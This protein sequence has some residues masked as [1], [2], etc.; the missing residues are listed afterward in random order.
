M[1]KDDEWTG[2]M[3]KPWLNPPQ[4]DELGVKRGLW[5]P[6]MIVLAL[7]VVAVIVVLLLV[8][9]GKLDR[10]WAYGVLPVAIIAAALSRVLTMF[11]AKAEDT[12]SEDRDH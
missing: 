10:A 12:P 4:N 1:A 6:T 5:G 2:S 11:K 3:K 7:T 8:D 9:Q